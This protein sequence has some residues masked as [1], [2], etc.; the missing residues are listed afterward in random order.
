[1]DRAIHK[2]NIE[3]ILKTRDDGTLIHRESQT[4]EFKESFNFSAVAE[5][6]RDFAAFANNKGG[7]LVCGVKDKPRREKVGLS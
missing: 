7:Y 3:D 2:Q 6:Y 5:Y 1:M 4:L